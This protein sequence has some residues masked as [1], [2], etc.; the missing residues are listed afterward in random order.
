MEIPEPL[1]LVY[2]LQLV[3]CEKLYNIIQEHN[4][5]KSNTVSVH[6]FE[7][8]PRLQCYVCVFLYSEGLNERY[9][10]TSFFFNLLLNP[11]VAVGSYA[12][13]ELSPT[14]Q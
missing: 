9:I 11:L 4:V 3:I 5:N 10:G 7:S 12:S 8:H 6:E 13:Q 2:S 1:V 14:L